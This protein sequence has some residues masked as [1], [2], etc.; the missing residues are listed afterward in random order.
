MVND[1]AYGHDEVDD[2]VPPSGGDV[3]DRRR[4][5]CYK[6][7]CPL[8]TMPLLPNAHLLAPPPLII[9]R[10]QSPHFIFV[11]T[12]ITHAFIVLISVSV[13]ISVSHVEG[14]LNFTNRPRS[15]VHSQITLVTMTISSP[16]HSGVHGR[17]VGSHV[18]L[19][20]AKVIAYYSVHIRTLTAHSWKHE[21]RRMVEKSMYPLDFL[22][23][24]E[25]YEGEGSSQGN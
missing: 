19:H 21:R 6:C 23:Q 13:P 17:S 12:S 15:L 11:V 5:C 7:D 9:P 2:D 4:D 18:H 10:L 16:I 1:Q 14:L 25:F 8:V 3:R 22:L 24:M 20:G